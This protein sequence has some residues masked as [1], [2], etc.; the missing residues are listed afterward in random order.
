LVKSVSST[1]PHRKPSRRQM[2]HHWDRTA[3][4]HH[5]QAWLVQGL[6]F[7]R[8]CDKS[9]KSHT[10]LEIFNLVKPVWSTTPYRKPS[11]RQMRYHWDRAA[12]HHHVQAWLVQ[13]LCFARDCDESVKSHTKLEIFHL[14]NP[15][16]STTPHRKPLRRQMR[17]RWDRTAV[18]QH[19]QAWL[20]QGVC[21]A[22]DCDESVKSHTKLEI[23]HLVNPVWS[24]TP[25]RKPLRRQMRY[26]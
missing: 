15:V 22:R 4:Y 23:V 5:V 14:V 8:D 20:V 11:K 13:G 1:T 6:C 3:V 9:V 21:F 25:H 10:K 19:V 7:A 16:W 26:H 24:T 18:H 17:Y 12:V 2:R